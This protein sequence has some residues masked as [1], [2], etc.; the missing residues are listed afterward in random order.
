MATIAPREGSKVHGLLWWITPACEQSLDFYEGYP[1]L[2]EKEQVT[3]RD[4]EGK[5]LT[6]MAY[7]MTGDERWM[8][9]TM[10]SAFYYRGIQDGYRQ[11]GLP[12]EELKKAWEHC[13]R[14]VNQE[15]VRINQMVGKRGKPPKEKHDQER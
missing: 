6:V 10:P 9:P 1:R 13:A 5:Q 15:T 8:S 11:N 14:E 3:V 4:S 2:Y 12:V 7:V